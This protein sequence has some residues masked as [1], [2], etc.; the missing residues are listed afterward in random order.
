M[1]DIVPW[2]VIASRI[3]KVHVVWGLN[4]F[5]LQL[6]R[7]SKKCEKERKKAER[8]VRDSIKAGNMDGAKIYASTAIREKNQ[9]LNYLKLASRIDAVAANVEN[10]LRMRGVTK[11]MQSVVK[12]MDSVLGTMN[13]E[14]ISGTM[15]RFESQMADLGVRT[16][17]MEGAMDST[18]AS[19]T[20]ETEVN[21]L[22]S[23]VAAANDLELGGQFEGLG[24]PT[25]AGVRDG[26][27]AA[28]EPAAVAAPAGGPDLGRGGSRDDGP[29]AGGGGGGAAA[30][31]GGGGDA[32]DRLAARLAALRG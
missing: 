12:G 6:Q 22:I 21:G 14:A 26:A 20:P 17:Y 23:E 24:A 1:R 31:G 8:K 30:G 2:A 5:A 4:L 7:Q 13:V 25:G 15:D 11:A 10:A 32:A 16:E 18:T 3:L 29:P 19:T 9:A 27:P 28:R